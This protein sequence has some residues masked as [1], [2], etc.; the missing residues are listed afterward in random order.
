GGLGGAELESILPL[1]GDPLLDPPLAAVEQIDKSGL[2]HRFDLGIYFTCEINTKDSAGTQE[3]SN[4]CL[5]AGRDRRPLPCRHG[6][7][8]Q[9]KDGMTL[10]RFHLAPLCEQHRIASRQLLL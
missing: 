3:N 9:T 8:L 2:R 6:P 1:L 5:K 4:D 7:G 10:R